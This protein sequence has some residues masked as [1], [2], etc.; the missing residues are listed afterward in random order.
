[1]W[2]AVHRATIETVVRQLEAVEAE[3]FLADVYGIALPEARLL[4]DVIRRGVSVALANSTIAA[5]IGMAYSQPR[6]TILDPNQ[7]L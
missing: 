2:V 7:S 6:A 3:R 5:E 4:R 1:M